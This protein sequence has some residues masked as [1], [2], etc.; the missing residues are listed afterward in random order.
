MMS[1]PFDENDA[2][3]ASIESALRGI[4]ALLMDRACGRSMSV[5]I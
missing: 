5:L 2:N 1:F 4:L 3:G